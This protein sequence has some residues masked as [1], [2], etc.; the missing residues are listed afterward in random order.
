[1]W[2]ES[3]ITYL[4]K[5]RKTLQETY[6]SDCDWSLYNLLRRV[7]LGFCRTAVLLSGMWSLPRAEWLWAIE[8]L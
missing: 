3:F 4:E 6:L 1:M 2:L 8:E 5:E 7:E